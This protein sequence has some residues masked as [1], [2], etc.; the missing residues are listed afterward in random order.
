MSLLSEA[1]KEC[2]LRILECG[3]PVCGQKRGVGWYHN[4]VEFIWLQI[5]KCICFRITREEHISHCVKR[6]LQYRLRCTAEFREGLIVNRWMERELSVPAVLFRTPRLPQESTSSLLDR[7]LQSILSKTTY[8][9]NCLIVQRC[10]RIRAS[11]SVTYIT[12]NLSR[13]TKQI[14]CAQRLGHVGAHAARFCRAL[15]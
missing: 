10:I 8:T 13:C 9:I 15:P 11:P 2:N 3:E 14:R 1:F 6:Y 12:F 4:T 5:P 7:T